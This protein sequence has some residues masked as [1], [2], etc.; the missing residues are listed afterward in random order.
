MDNIADNFHGMLDHR[1]GILSYEQYLKDLPEKKYSKICM[2][3]IMNADVMIATFGEDEYNKTS[4]EIL[5]MG[6][7]AYKMMGLDHIIKVYVHTYKTF[8]A[9]ANDDISDDDFL[10]LM[11]TNHEQYELATASQT[12]LGGVSR[13]VV[14]FGDDLIDRVKSA[15]Y[16]NRHSQT[17]FIVATDER[18]R[19]KA[20]R[21][22]Q[23]KK[24]ELLNYAITNN[25]VVP[26]YQGIRNNESG[27]ITKYE[28]LMRIFDQDDKMYAPGMFLDAAKSLKLY[29]PLS[30]IMI[31]R[32][33]RDFE[34]KQSDLSLNISLYD[35][36]SEEFKLWFLDRL[37]KHSDPSKIIV[38]F[39]ETE[40]YNDNDELREFLLAVRDIGCKIAI[41]DFGVGFATYNSIISLRPDIIKVDGAIIK[42]LA[43]DENSRLVLDAICYMSRLIQSGIVAEFVENEAIQDLV[44]KN[45]VKFSQGYHFSKPE[46]IEN[47][48][49][50]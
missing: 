3:E 25:K 14:A 10:H 27:E 7:E 35:I 41:D 6:N 44:I 2:T 26:F 33:L 48:S 30:K 31:D 19:L 1:F 20:E 21:S 50:I 46:P 39:V 42:H 36:Q 32:A 47:L 12:D 22:T 23:V 40:N 4:S 5:N 16:I 9:V 38:E 45:G 17:N 15:Y 13:F 11:K 24:F 28:A 29:L 8:M 18:A 37:A 43:N 34:G 49:V